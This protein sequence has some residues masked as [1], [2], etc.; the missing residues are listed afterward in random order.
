MNKINPHHYS[1]AYWR[2]NL[3]TIL[4]GDIEIVAIEP[5]ISAR[6]DGSDTAV[7][8]QPDELV[9]AT[10]RESVKNNE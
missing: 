9:H 7:R 1:R 8:L 4:D 5:V 6:I 10:A 3:A 2:G